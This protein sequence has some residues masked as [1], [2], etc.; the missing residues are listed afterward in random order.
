MDERPDI[1]VDA[2]LTELAEISVGAAILGLRRI[3]IERRKLVQETP[4]LEPVV[5]A[6]L[7]QID[8]LAQPASALVGAALAGLGDALDDERGHKLTEAGQLIAEL[9]P[10]LVRLSGLT[11]RD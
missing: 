4:A 11:K 6:V 1:D 3:N 7:D 9:G 10:E 2:I 5:D 8:A